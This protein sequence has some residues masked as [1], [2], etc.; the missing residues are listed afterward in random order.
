[1]RKKKNYPKATSDPEE[2]ARRLKIVGRKI[3]NLKMECILYLTE[4][5]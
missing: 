5:Y 4:L 2:V 1:V 3:V